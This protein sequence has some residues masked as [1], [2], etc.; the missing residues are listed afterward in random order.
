M[1][2]KNLFCATLV[3]GECNAEFQ[4]RQFICLGKITEYN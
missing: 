4:N 3:Y 1:L 2:K